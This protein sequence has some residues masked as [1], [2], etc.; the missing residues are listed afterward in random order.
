VFR[1]LPK[2]LVPISGRPYLE[3]LFDWLRNFG[4]RRIVLSLGYQADAV[5]QYLRLHQPDNI[6]LSIVVEPKPLGTAGAIRFARPELRSDPAMIMNGDSF[7][8]AD[9]CAFLECYRTSRAIG[10]IVCAEVEDA[11]RYGRVELDRAGRI[12]GFVEKGVT[13]R[14]SNMISAG[15]YLFS[16][17]LLDEIAAGNAT[18]VEHDVFENL[19]AGA[20]SA[21][22][23]RFRF[24]DIGTPE[25]LLVAD[26]ILGQGLSQGPKY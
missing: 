22:T 4:A 12:C 25:S 15:V 21:Y 13:S 18:S 2:L 23:G 7:T 26:A 9:L 5:I 10:S 19:P 24:I 17:A 20:L 3:Y 6:E 14:G 1:D 11:S 16:A 8:S